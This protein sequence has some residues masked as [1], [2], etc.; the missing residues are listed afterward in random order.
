MGQQVD[1]LVVGG[2]AVGMLAALGLSSQGYTVMLASSIELGQTKGQRLFALN[3]PACKL[4][5]KVSVWEELKSPTRVK[6]MQVAST[7]TPG[8]ALSASQAGLASL[9]YTIEEQDLIQVLTN[10]INGSAIITQTATN[11]SNLATTATKATINLDGKQITAKLLVGA[12]GIESEVAKLAGLYQ[13]PAQLPYSAVV[14]RLEL[15]LNNTA[16]QWMNEQGILALLPGDPS[17]LIW[18]CEHEQ[19]EQ[20]QQYSDEEF[21]NALQQQTSWDTLPRNL[22]KRIKFPLKETVRKAS[23]QRTVLL[24]DSTHSFHPLAGQGLAVGCGDVA[25]LLQLVQK[26]PG[27]NQVV[28]RYRRLRYLRAKTT[29]LLT[30]N[31]AKLAHD[32]PQALQL[33]LR[34]PVGK[35]LAQLANTP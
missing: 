3:N 2:G 12:D 21:I 8:L 11:L 25:T 17:C 13:P 31:L 33:G 5:R 29:Q 7:T 4:L 16:Y 20:L 9:C 35:V 23:T 28:G 24:G 18:S 14:A 10:K 32:K 15:P 6:G 1:I 22:S 26:D 27:T 19:A 30:H 34:M